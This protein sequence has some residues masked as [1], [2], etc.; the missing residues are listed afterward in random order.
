MARRGPVRAVADLGTILQRFR[1]LFQASGF[2]VHGSDM[3]V[4]GLGPVGAVAHRGT[5]LQRYRGISLMSVQFQCESLSGHL[6]CS[7][8][9]RQLSE[10]RSEA[11][12]RSSSLLSYRSEKGLKP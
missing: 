1:V 4:P 12:G 6:S 8:P 9:A 2:R 5:I 10:H 7:L 3:R 11:R